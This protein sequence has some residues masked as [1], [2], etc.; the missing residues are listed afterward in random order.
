MG[1]STLIMATEG[2]PTLAVST[3]GNTHVLMLNPTE[4]VPKS[5]AMVTVV[6]PRSMS[7]LTLK[8]TEQVTP[9]QASFNLQVAV[10]N[11][12][13]AHSPCAA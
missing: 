9:E 11:A 1:T 8:R 2:Q 4:Q 13:N 10:S 7:C 3:S 6:M 5:C 12:F